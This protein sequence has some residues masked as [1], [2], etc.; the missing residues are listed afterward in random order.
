MAPQDRILRSWGAK[1]CGPGERRDW[2]RP[3]GA[4]WGR[5]RMGG[6]AGVTDRGRMPPPP[7]PPRFYADWYAWFVERYHPVAASPGEQALVTHIAG[8]A[9]SFAQTGLLPDVV[10]PAEPA[11]GPAA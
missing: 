4:R 2:G 7:P 9:R 10:P 5:V 3:Q 6:S 1:V 11:A 8:D